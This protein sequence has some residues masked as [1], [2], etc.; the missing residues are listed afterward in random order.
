MTQFGPRL[1]GF[2][3]ALLITGMVHAA[4]L[5]LPDAD[6]VSLADSC[7]VL[8]D[9]QGQYSIADVQTP[10]TA[11]GF[12]LQR[13]TSFGYR[14]GVVWLRCAVQRQPW[15]ARNW[16][17]EIQA[18]ILNQATL[19]MQDEHGAF[20]VRSM[21]NTLPWAQR[22]ID[23]RNPLFQLRLADTASHVFYLQLRS[24]TT[25]TLLPVLWSWPGFVSASLKE[26][27]AFGLFIAIDVLMLLS[28]LWFFLTLR[29][30]LYG[31]LTLY[32]LC[33]L[34]TT[35]AS[36]G[37]TYQFLL[38]DLPRANEWL[39]MVSLYLSMPTGGELLLD[40]IRLG[41]KQRPPWLRVFILTCW[42]FS[43]LAI[44]LLLVFNQQWVR[45][46]FQLWVLGSMGLI[47]VLTVRQ[48]LG[49]YREV[50][51]IFLGMIPSWLAV[52][53]LSMRNI[54]YVSPGP[55]I[56]HAY[57]ICMAFY[58]LTLQYAVSRRVKR[59]HDENTA[60]REKAL[61]QARQAE[62][63]LETLVM[64]RT[65]ELQQ[66]LLQVESALALER[67]V[68]IEQQEFFATVSHELRTPLTVIDMTMQNMELDD[69]AVDAQTRQRYDKIVRATSRLTSI[70]DRYL[71]E[72]C[73]AML[74]RGPHFQPCQLHRLLEDTAQAATVL[75]RAHR[76]RL[77]LQQLPT[78][79]V[80]DADAL[81]LVLRTLADNAVKYTP[82][83]AEIIISGTLRENG[84]ELLVS[85][86]GPGMS[87]ATLQHV[88]QQQYRGPES[89]G[90]PGSGMGLL[91]ARRLIENQGGSI[92]IHSAPQQGT[93][94]RIWL[95]LHESVQTLP[96]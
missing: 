87:P 27:L 77:E 37:Y 78:H 81:M 46:L 89:T 35:L 11:A 61:A 39:L 8:F 84:L 1:Y 9:P 67:K 10:A 82:A 30:S 56:D 28:A 86:N 15:Q 66:A 40:Y 38:T 16:L 85:D 57:F 75:S 74:K 55:V 88:F 36:E 2:L 7:S 41:R 32:L 93:H 17:L 45:P 80:C 49:G 95:P 34:L 65:R 92:G 91:L 18:P 60:N 69:S 48:L 21:G 20:S 24:N 23:Y 6:R 25:L 31:W 59:L 4:S 44:L 83:Q 29:E 3:L 71:D 42:A 96:D 47:T 26:Q 73:F 19:Y 54:G 52:V 50:W 14:K 5:Q 33:N 13:S 62:H 51:A 72:D 43:I 70:L 53:G 94:I 58:L 79:F 64:Q 12:A 76:F 22:E 90:K 68:Q 63:E